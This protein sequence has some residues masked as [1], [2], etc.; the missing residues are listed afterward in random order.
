[1]KRAWSRCEKC[2]WMEEMKVPD[3]VIDSFED[4]ISKSN[5]EAICFGDCDATTPHN[6]LKYP[7]GYLL[8]DDG[9]YLN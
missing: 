7:L 5:G 1:M 9:A 4:D 2:L 6:L 8:V 3:W